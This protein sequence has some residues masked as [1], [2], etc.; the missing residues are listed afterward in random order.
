MEVAA[1]LTEALPYIQNY[2]GKTIVIKYGG[3]AMLSQEL[4]E[5]IISDIVLLHM[6]GVKVVLLCRCAVFPDSRGRLYVRVRRVSY[7]VCED[8]QLLSLPSY[9]EFSLC[10]NFLTQVLLLVQFLNYLLRNNV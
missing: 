2:I 7:L 8:K 1:I 3:N 6:I 5:S 9:Q 4:K 10:L